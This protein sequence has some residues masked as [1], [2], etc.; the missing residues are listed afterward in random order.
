MRFVYPRYFKM[1]VTFF[2]ISSHSLSR[3]SFS[4]LLD[5]PWSQ[6]SSLAPP[7]PRVRAFI[8]I[9]HR[10][11]SAFPL[12]VDFHGIS[13]THALAILVNPYF[14]RNKILSYHSYY[15]IR[16]TRTHQTHHS[17]HAD[18]LPSHRGRPTYEPMTEHHWLV[19]VH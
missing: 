17:R 10:V 16:E 15:D 7:P 9:A 1:S 6:V 2:L 11:H 3:L 5:K 8:F 12:L 19:L 4:D 18:L 14:M 13:V